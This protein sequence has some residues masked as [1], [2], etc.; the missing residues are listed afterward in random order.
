VPGSAAA[1]SLLVMKHTLPV[2]RRALGWQGFA[3]SPLDHAAGN[4]K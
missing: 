3:A 1:H 2:F 4:F